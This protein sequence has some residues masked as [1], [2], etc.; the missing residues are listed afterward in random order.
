MRGLIAA[1]LAF[2]LYIAAQASLFHFVTIRRKLRA[3]LLVLLVGIAVYAAAYA[4]LS[5]DATYLPPA[6]AAA[7]DWV[8][9][10]NGMFI[11]WGLF[12][13][14][15]QFVNMADNSV[16]VRS[17]IEFDRGPVQG[18]TL[19][20]LEQRYPYGDMLSHRIDRLVAGG[21]LAGAAGG[22]YRCTP[23]GA[24]VARVFSILKRVLGLGPGG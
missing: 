18:L 23:K 20:E 1:L 9:W 2:L 13:G 10:L 16:G 21:F 12:S 8:N 19:S 11:Y 5:D 3:M 7:S 4:V 6:L 24:R 15:Y 17:L 14:Y 22:R